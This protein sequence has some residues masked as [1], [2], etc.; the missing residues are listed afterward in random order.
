MTSKTATMQ[1]ITLAGLMLMLFTGACSGSQPST[2]PTIELARTPRPTFTPAAT[3]AA[4]PSAT[5]FPTV[6]LTRL[7]ASPSAQNLRA[8]TPTVAATRS[9]WHTADGVKV[10]AGPGT[11]YAF[12]GELV[13]NADVNVIGKSIDRKWLFIS[14]PIRGW[15]PAGAVEVDWLMPLAVLTAIPL[16]VPTET[17]FVV[18]SFMGG[19]V[20]VQTVVQTVI[21]NIV[22]T[23]TPGPTQTPWIVVVTPTFPSSPTPAASPTANAS[24]TMPPSPTPPPSPTGVPSTSTPTSTSTATRTATATAT[25]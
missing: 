19:S 15:I 14:D 7:P 18:P 11:A 4:I 22:V 24:P 6:D 5:L 9:A 23:A 10:F 8:S 20:D 2:L 13:A 16:P 12:V 21:Q 3:T 17:P 1:R 25:P